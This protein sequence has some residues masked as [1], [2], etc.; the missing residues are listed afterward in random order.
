LV[1]V[2]PGLGELGWS[3]VAVS[4]VG[5]VVVVVDAVVL[6]EDLGFEERVEDP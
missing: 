1:V 5:S 3:E 2:G 4:A 6:D